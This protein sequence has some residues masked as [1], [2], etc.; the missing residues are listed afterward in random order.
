MDETFFR[1]EQTF[2]GSWMRHVLAATI[3][4]SLLIVFTGLADMEA[5]GIEVGPESVGRVLF[6]L[7]IG[8]GLPVL[9]FSLKL[10]IEERP[11]G[12]FIRYRPFV[13]RLIS[14]ESI[15]SCNART[16]QPIAEYGGWGIRCGWLQKSG[17]AYNVSG[18][19]GVQLVFWDET[20]L[21][22]GSQDADTLAT[23][24]RSRM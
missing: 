6:F 21:L 18:N 15:Q 19:R 12:L 10:T 3:A 2:V 14:Y 7:F 16:Y 4:M 1:E 24:I 23:A 22:I 13:R 8:M 9:F 20:K 5:G 17:R 11:E